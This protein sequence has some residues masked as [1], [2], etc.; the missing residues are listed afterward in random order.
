M[1]WIR[2][3]FMDNMSWEMAEVYGAITDQILINLA[4]YF[5]YWKSGNVPK[6]AFEYQATM[7]AQ[8][9]QVNR[10]TIRIIRQ[11]LKGAN[12]ALTNVLEQAIMEAVSKAQ[13]ELL[14]GVKA[15][16]LKPAGIPIVDPEQTRAFQLYYQQA[17]QKL[18]L[19]NTVML[20]STK[21]AYQ[22]T[23]SDIVNRVQ[24]TQTALDVGA[25]EV[26]TGVSSW[27]QALRHSIERMKQNGITGFIDHGGHRWSAEAY[28]A[29]DIRTT[30]ANTARAAVWETNQDFGNDL[31]LVSYHQGAR[32]LCYPWQNK[33]ISA[34]DRY[35][36]TYDLD[37]NE[38]EIIPQR[39]TSYGEPAGLFGINCKHYP[40][41]FIPGV[42][43]ITGQPQ[44]PEENEQTYKESQQQR[45]LEREIRE[46][47]RDLL[48]MKA[49][50][51][52]PE[53]IKAQRARIRETDDRIDAFCEQTGRA[54]RQSREGAF[55]QRSF[56]D[57]DTYDVTTFE[58]QQ[59]DL[60][61]D[62]FRSG[63]VQK[64]YTFGQMT[65]KE[66]ITPTNIPVNIGESLIDAKIPTPA[67]PE[68][69]KAATIPDIS[70][71]TLDSS[72]VTERPASEQAILTRFDR[73]DTSKRTEAQMLAQVN[74]N[75]TEGRYEW[76]NNCQRTVAAQEL[77]YRGYDVTAMPYKA[78]DPMS[79]IAWNAWQVPTDP[80]SDPDIS[81]LGNKSTFIANIEKE[82]DRWGDGSRAIVR[83]KWNQSSG[84][85]GH[86]IFAR[87]VNGS[88]IYTDPQ[89][90]TV[91]DITE[92]LSHTTRR[93]DQM[94]V[95][96]VDNRN[97]SNN[98]VYAVKNRK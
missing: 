41:P 76:V 29:M 78:S 70:D 39:L 4:R 54:R 89:N 91:L 51:A 25:G 94:W 63:G 15:G 67:V 60:I 77:V 14:K 2:P 73:F 61:D 57:P 23:V 79:D 7:L 46:Q 10:D 95:M 40:T 59:K 86:F 58:R 45:A 11:G 93:K 3:S 21:Q 43:V 24:A 90:D 82:F 92:T 83:V 74:P 98:I 55:T 71:K 22:A 30:V 85:N 5:P 66:P 75:Y 35:G 26:V 69:V 50:G 8:M 19:V 16:L 34:N 13:P 48:M 20:E 31:Y 84:G 27:N 36:T 65:P 80:Y 17:A 68:E 38:I 33:V 42:S 18:N 56:P 37:G 6:S 12:S 96:R 9:G 49:Q 72:V 53:E 88:I 44:S 47:K 81:I 62:Y 1:A 87:R 64:D 52:T 97:V 28:T 32:P